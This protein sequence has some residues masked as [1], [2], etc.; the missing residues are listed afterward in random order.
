MSFI[1][2]D[3]R[4][5]RTKHTLVCLR[6]ICPQGQKNIWIWRINVKVQLKIIFHRVVFVPSLLIFARTLKLFVNVIRTMKLRSMKHFLSKSTI[7]YLTNSCLPKA[8]L[9]FSMFSRFCNHLLKAFFPSGPVLPLALFSSSYFA[10]WPFHFSVL[11]CSVMLYSYSFRN[12]YRSYYMY[13]SDLDKGSMC[14][15]KRSIFCHVEYN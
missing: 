14:S 6:D 9:F 4:V 12:Y 2:S 1:Y 8:H 3:V 15:R 5:I 7:Q 13:F 11:V 10:L